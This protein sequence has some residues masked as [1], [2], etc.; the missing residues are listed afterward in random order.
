M[1]EKWPANLPEPRIVW[2]ASLAFEFLRESADLW[3]LAARPADPKFEE[4]REF[5]TA[6]LRVQLVFLARGIS[7]WLPPAKANEV[8]GAIGRR[9]FVQ[10][11]LAF[12]P[13]ADVAGAELRRRG[14]TRKLPG[15]EAVAE[16]CPLL[17][18][19]FLNH[20]RLLNDVVTV[21]RRARVGA[22]AETRA[23]VERT[24]LTLN[25]LPEPEGVD[26]GGA[27]ERLLGGDVDAAAE[28]SRLII[29]DRDYAALAEGWGVS[30][31]RAGDDGGESPTAPAHLDLTDRAILFVLRP[32]G[33]AMTAEEISLR[34]D[35]LPKAEPLQ[36]ARGGAKT[37]LRHLRRLERLR[38]VLRSSEVT[39][40]V[41]TAAG[42]MRI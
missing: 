15:L 38:L 20:S 6:S 37:I 26:V 14:K 5:R 30:P 21:L 29:L 16:E 35:C 10:A 13:V 17:D 40:F 27:I 2:G 8:T 3:T 23:F 7:R 12:A 11:Q 9:D 39:G 25:S 18:V 41:L 33:S 19:S 1:S 34:I 36:R 22:V 31:V 4:V 32:A 24:E 42:D 28:T